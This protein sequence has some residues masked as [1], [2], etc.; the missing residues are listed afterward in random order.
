MKEYRV[1]FVNEKGKIDLMLVHA[2]SSERAKEI[3][4]Q[5]VKSRGGVPEIKGVEE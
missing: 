4:K 5:H 2:D 3:V 1:I